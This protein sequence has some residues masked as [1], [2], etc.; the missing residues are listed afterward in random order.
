MPSPTDDPRIETAV[1]LGY[2]ADVIA[3]VRALRGSDDVRVDPDRVA[4]FGRSMG[5]GV[6][7]R[8]SRPSPGSSPPASVGRRSPAWR[9]RTSTSSSARTRRCRPGPGSSV[10]TACRD[11]G[12]A[13]F[14]RGV[15]SRPAFDQITEPV[16]LVHGGIDDTCPPAW[17]RATYRALDGAGRRLA[18]W[19]GTTTRSTRSVRRFV[20]AMDRTVDFFDRRLA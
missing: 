10:A 6:I 7:S 1:R 19:S 17:A 14:W 16:L 2:S 13:R 3:A 12:A 20:A 9:P 15:S 18:R 8:R 4:L 11:D 5:G